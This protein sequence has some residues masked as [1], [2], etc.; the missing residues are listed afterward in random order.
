MPATE[1]PSDHAAARRPPIWACAALLV[2]VAVYTL[3]VI[4]AV[5]GRGAIWHDEATSVMGATGHLDDW[6]R[7]E[8]DKVPP[9]G[10]WATAADYQEFQSVDRPLDLQ[11][12]SR[13]LGDHDWAPPGFFWLLH[14]ALLVGIPVLWAGPVVNVLLAAAGTVIAFRMVFH[15]TGSALGAVLA[16]A[17]ALWS[18][19]LALAGGEA[20]HYPLYGVMLLALGCWGVAAITE[21]RRGGLGR[22]RLFGLGGITLMGLL[23]NHQFL[24]NGIAAVLL[25]VVLARPGRRMALQIG[26]AFLGGAVVSWLV[27]PYYFIH[28]GRLGAA[29]AGFRL[30]LVAGRASRWLTGAFDVITLDRRFGDL[31]RL[32]GRLLVTTAVLAVVLFHRRLIGWVRRE[33]HLAFP[34]LLTIASLLIPATGYALQR[35]LVFVE[36]GHYI[37]P[38]WPLTIV[39]IAIVVV[40]ARP[41]AGSAIVGVVAV[42][43]L[44]SSVAWVRSIAPI[45]DATR[46]LF[47]TIAS[48]DGIVVDCVA[49]GYFPTVVS[50]L[51]PDTP[52][53]AARGDDLVTDLENGFE[54]PGDRV[55]LLHAPCGSEADVFAAFA[56]AGFGDPTE[57]GGLERLRVWWIDTGG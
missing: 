20:R 44:I 2:V 4:A 6:Y 42:V 39:S 31:A 26:A 13:S 37:A 45:G 51:D 52:V 18:P 40:S 50:A 32:T 21:A 33:P 49:R 23:A 54:L 43:L 53:Y 29:T 27:F 9:Y 7:F 55:V 10:V 3:L 38:L 15:L 22:G 11:G 17:A 57:V 35:V 5:R 1:T 28:F 34:A 8:F 47:A 56:A 19:A 41:R 46:G 24:F 36:G 25:V 12:V 16:A 14:L 30:D 48:A